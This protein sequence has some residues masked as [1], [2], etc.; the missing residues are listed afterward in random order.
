MSSPI[1]EV[2]MPINDAWERALGARDPRFDGIFYV[3]II[4]TKVYCR[5]VCPA[6]VSYHDHRRFFETAA[7]AERAGFRPCLRCRPELAPGRALMDAV[8][9]LARVAAYRIEAG[10]LNGHDVASLAR[11]LGVSERHLR[12]ALER[13]IGVS[14]V[15]LAQ[16]H[17]LLLAKRLLA[18]TS[19]PVTRIAFAAGFQSLRRFN[20]VFRERY[21]LSPSSLRRRPNATKP[22]READATSPV[23]D[24][25]R[26]TLAYRPPLAWGVLLGTIGREAVP[27]MEVLRE[28]RYGRTVDLDGRRGVVFVGNGAENGDARRDTRNHLNFD[29]SPALVPVLMPLLARL[30]HLFDLDSE[31]TVIDAHLTQG[32]LGT[33][34]RRHPGVRLPG[35]LEGFEVALRT[36]LRGTARSAAASTLINRVYAAL[37]ESFETGDPDLT[38][39]SPSAA[40]VADAGATGLVALGVPQPKA[41]A[42]SSVAKSVEDGSL[43]LS[44]HSP[45]AGT[46]DALVQA[47]GVGDRLATT[48]VMHALG[49]PDAFPASDRGLQ[50]AAGVTSARLLLARAEQWRPWR[51]YA[52][53]HLWLSQQESSSGIAD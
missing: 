53:S 47:H 12:R 17:R 5:P 30:R 44:P 18:D 33:L 36:L 45:L 3:G 13:E 34:V 14:P 43:H 19:L 16:T 10:A 51:A 37:G 35:A 31:P 38:L 32:G 11:E 29:I 23:N 26:L 2:K 46:H 15:E 22:P 8:P 25:V 40:R 41:E 50:R 49:W 7:S 28:G 4:T 20:S 1:R 42:L 39:L 52:A 27:G 24:L 21:R 6:R 9:R 48:I